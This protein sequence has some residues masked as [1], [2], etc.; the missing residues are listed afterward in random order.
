MATPAL[1]DSCSDE[2]PLPLMPT[3]T[4]QL[5]VEIRRQEDRITRAAYE[6][7]LQLE[8][9]EVATRG[10][11]NNFARDAWK[12]LYWGYDDQCMVL[13]PEEVS[14]HYG[15]DEKPADEKEAGSSRW[16]KV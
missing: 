4:A 10:R 3:R 7:T 11:A 16:E 1:T 15:P 5:F 13:N 6:R 8:F 2:V 12:T 14:K 9:G